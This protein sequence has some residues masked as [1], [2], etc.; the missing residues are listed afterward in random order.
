V[1]IVLFLGLLIWFVGERGK[2]SLPSTLEFIREGGIKRFF[3]LST[4]HGYL[5]LRWQKPYI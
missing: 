3:S 4:L 2:L 5:Y 1:S